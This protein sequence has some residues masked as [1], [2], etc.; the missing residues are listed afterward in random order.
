MKTSPASRRCTFHLDCNFVS[1]R[2]EFVRDLLGRVADMGY[3]A[4]LWELEDQVHWE[5]SP[6]CANTDS[7]SK[8]DFRS[9]LEYSRSLGL[10]PIPL[11]QTIGHGEYVMMH[12][13]YHSFR[14]H[15]EFS[16]CYCVSNPEVRA[17]LKRWIGE[18]CDLF[19][20]VELFHLGGDEAYRFGTCEL[21][22]P[23]ERNE[24]YAEHLD[25]LATVLRQ[26]NI[27]PGIWHDMILACPGTIQE[28]SK[29]YLIWDWNYEAGIRPAEAV[30]IWGEGRVA[31]DDLTPQQKT[32]FP[33]I[34]DSDGG[35][36]PFYTTDFLVNHGYDVVLC[37]AARASQSG[38]FCPKAEAHAEN[39]A[40]VAR[41]T[42][43]AGLFGQCVTDWAVRLNPLL[44]GI[45]MLDLPNQLNPTLPPME[46]IRLTFAEHFGFTE[47]WDAAVKLGACD[48]R[49]RIFSAIQWSGLKDSRPAPVHYIKNWVVRWLEE[50]EMH[51]SG[52]HEMFLAMIA[53]TESGLAMLNP[54]SG[55]TPLGMLWFRAGEIQLKYLHLLD[56]VLSDLPERPALRRELQALRGEIV[57]FYSGEQTRT[58]AYK[59]AALI[60][61]PLLEF[62]ED[63]P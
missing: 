35:L 3:N 29:E 17:F 43:S 57:E 44:A 55:K 28:I 32:Q 1:L 18:I 12:E 62:L 7:W 49:V 36:N 31:R 47:A 15:P 33:E 56:E 11:L 40:A 27:R 45:P 38:P 30:R 41:K 24:L 48:Y 37:S 22:A 23:R 58:S 60:L 59:N 53:S 13:R 10:E 54:H 25:E 5:T 39:I 50:D 14:E 63:R 51:W 61:D 19:G 34:L 2:P 26:R 21:C 4:I 16:D 9:I 46:S 52:R 8:K 20:D 6:E 42:D